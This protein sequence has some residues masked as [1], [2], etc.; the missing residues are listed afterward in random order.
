MQRQRKWG[1]IDN[2]N[3]LTSCI[4]N[5]FKK[6]KSKT[7]LKKKMEK[8]TKGNLNLYKHRNKVYFD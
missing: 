8:V 6:K 3:N 4:Q 1:N 2:N 7:N 5:G